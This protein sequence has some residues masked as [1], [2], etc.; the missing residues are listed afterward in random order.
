MFLL[1]NQSESPAVKGV[2]RI[3]CERASGGRGS[4]RRTRWT[5]WHRRLAGVVV[6]HLGDLLVA[7]PAGA[8]RVHTRNGFHRRSS[9]LLSERLRHFLSVRPG[10]AR[11]TA[12][13]NLGAL[14]VA[15]IRENRAVVFAL[16]CTCVRDRIR[17][18]SID[19]GSGLEGAAR[20]SLLRPHLVAANERRN[21]RRAV[22]ARGRG[23][24]LLRL[25]GRLV[26]LFSAPDRHGARDDR[27][28]TRM[29]KRDARV[30]LFDDL[31]V[32]G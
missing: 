16:D 4:L 28:F 21:Q 2:F 9:L 13:A 8:P 32:D 15:A 24:I 18:E 5:P 1:L 30:L 14:R 19:R 7:C 22:D 11:Q 6:P 12:S 26:V 17:G 20:A 31:R 10:A 23:R 25:S 27:D 29:A 3:A